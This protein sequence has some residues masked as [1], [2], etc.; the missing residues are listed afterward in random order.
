MECSG[1]ITAN[2]TASL[3]FAKEIIL[4]LNVKPVE[5]INEWYKLNSS[6]SEHVF[7]KFQNTLII[8]VMEMVIIT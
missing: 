7:L 5:K 2:G 8:L 1:I 4:Y 6:N 3:E